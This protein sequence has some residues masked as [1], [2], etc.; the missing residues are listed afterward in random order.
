M[1]GRQNPLTTVAVSGFVLLDHD[2]A[3]RPTTSV[4]LVDAI[5]PILSCTVNGHETLP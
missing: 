3:S 2:E 1:P 5:A 4:T